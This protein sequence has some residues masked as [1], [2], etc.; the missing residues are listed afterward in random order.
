MYR[1]ILLVLLLVFGASTLVLANFPA[2]EVWSVEF[3]SP[4]SCYG[5][6]WQEDN[7]TF[8]LLGMQN[9]VVI[10]SEGEIVWESQEFDGSITAVNRFYFDEDA[11][12]QIVLAVNEVEIDLGPYRLT[13][14]FIYYLFGDNYEEIERIPAFVSEEQNGGPDQHTDLNDVRSIVTFDNFLPNRD[15]AIITINR[16]YYDSYSDGP[17]GGSGGSSLSGSTYLI[18]YN[19]VILANHRIGVPMVSTI[20]QFQ[21]ENEALVIGYRS[22]SSYY[23][24]ISGGYSSSCGIRVIPDDFSEG[25]N[26]VLYSINRERRTSVTGLNILSDQSDELKI[27][28]V[29]SDTSR[30]RRWYL[31]K[32]SF[33]DLATEDIIELENGNYA[34]FG[35][36]MDDGGRI[37]ENLLCIGTRDAM[38]IDLDDFWRIDVMD[39]NIPA[40]NML[41]IGNYDNDEEFEL[42]CLGE[43]SLILYNLGA[44]SVPT[45]S[46]SYSPTTYTIQ[47]AY[48]NPFNSKTMIE[49]SLP[50]AGRYS[51]VVYDVNGAEIT[52]LADEWK[53]AGQYRLA[54]DALGEASG[55]Y[56]IKLGVDGQR[57]TQ[58]IQLVK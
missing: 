43:N 23:N 36:P 29:Y 34:L 12:H 13:H 45:N 20:Y 17:N 2:E 27:C 32:F 56:F 49:Y 55:T 39:H 52:R 10:V 30:N 3:D 4:I 15:R 44:L 6:S 19:N 21:N 31:G 8:F 26:R 25:T 18:D 7:Q 1:K 33:D 50:R 38:I 53:S 14:G 5:T 57:D 37:T 22:E 58:A 40:H 28:A 46:H 11:G 47:S 48:P 51:L 41:D 35:Y 54:W 42:I 16:S 24:P 9:I